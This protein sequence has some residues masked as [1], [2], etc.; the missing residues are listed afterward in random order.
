MP[1]GHSWPVRGEFDH[2]PV[3]GFYRVALQEA[4]RQ[5]APFGLPMRAILLY[6]TFRDADGNLYATLRKLG[7]DNAAPFALQTT[8]GRDRF[9]MNPDSAKAFQGWGVVESLEGDE[10]TYRNV[11][12]GAGGRPFT[13]RRR[14]DGSEWTE[15]DLLSLRGQLVGDAG[16]QWYDPSSPGA[17]YAA[18]QY[19]ASGVIGGTEVEGFF[20]FDQLYFAPGVTW[21]ESP[22]FSSPPYLEVAWHTFGVEYED[23][24]IEAGQVFHG[25]RRLGFALILGRDAPLIASRDVVAEIEVA[26]DGYPARLVYT[27][28]GERWIWS[29]DPKGPM[30]DFARGYPRGD[31]Y[32][33]S[34]GLFMR[35]GETRAPRVWWSFIDTFVDG[36]AKW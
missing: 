19:R 31:L 18:E 9:G 16:L 34:E 21:F 14:R 4:L 22:Y 17:Y 12:E 33:P 5:R 3:I 28:D 2:Q 36:R 20:C 27:I 15:S 30:P 13:F 24:T 10:H 25:G 23:G 7:L 6:G 29:A 32:R 11:E 26:E 35:E 8:V 1:A